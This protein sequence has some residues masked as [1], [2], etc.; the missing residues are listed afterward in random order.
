MSLHDDGFRI[1]DEVVSGLIVSQMPEWSGLRLQRLDTAGTVNVAYR[2]GDD[3]LVRLPRLAAFSKGPL[4]ES[5][6]LPEFAPMLPFQIP[7]YLALGVPTDGYP[8]AWSVLDWIQGENATPAVLS[9]LN[10]A[11]E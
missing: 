9:D 11:A 8:S 10:R 1:D 7:A 5:R 4:R 6:W 2:L 3:K